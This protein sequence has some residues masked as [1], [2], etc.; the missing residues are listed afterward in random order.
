MASPFENV[1]AASLPADALSALAELRTR[2]KL[3]MAMATER[4]W[5]RFPAADAA[6]LRV[7]LPLPGLDLYERRGDAWYRFAR[8]L[9]SFDFPEKLE[10]R[11]LN[12]VL[13]PGPLDALS[14]PAA[15]EAPE[16]L[17]L[18]ADP[19]PRP[20]SAARCL[21]AD[22]A[23]W[24]DKVPAARLAQLEAVCRGDEILVRGRRLPPLARARLYWGRTVLIPLGRRPEPDVP[25]QVLREA[26][27]VE[28][29]EL[30]LWEVERVEALDSAMLQPLSRAAI[31]LACAEA[32][33]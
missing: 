17:R 13:F 19:Y 20:A 4:I 28:P 6:V 7:I 25:E 3:T 12:E 10:N 30:I 16:S 27:G 31:R 14:P 1:A 21:I 11:P 5:L 26:F 24:A 22:L 2:P 33:P 8:S 15:R 29:F 9:P 32:A 18:I 23:R